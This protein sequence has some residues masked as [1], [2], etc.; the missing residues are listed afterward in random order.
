LESEAKA[1]RFYDKI[2]AK[3]LGGGFNPSKI[4]QVRTVLRLYFAWN[5]S[6]VDLIPSKRKIIPFPN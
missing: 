6:Q 5:L 3:S 4:N 1:S 2:I